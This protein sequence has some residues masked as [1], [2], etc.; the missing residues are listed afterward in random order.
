VIE[1]GTYEELCGHEQSRFREMVQSSIA[2]HLDQARRTQVT[3]LLRH[4]KD[5][6][7]QT[8]VWPL[9]RPR[10]IHVYNLGAGRT[11]TT[12]ITEVFSGVFRASHEAH[13]AETATLLSDYLSDTVSKRDVKRKLI[14]RDRR[15]RLEFESSPFLAGLSAP[16]AEAFPRAQFLLTVRPPREWL[17]SNIDKCINS[18]RTDLPP[19]F[20]HLRDLNYGPPPE[21]YPPPESILSHYNL[22]SLSGFLK[23]RSWHHATVLDSIPS[24]RRL[25]IKTSN[26]DRAVPRIANFLGVSR[27]RLSKSPKKNAAPE[28]H[29]ILSKIDHDYVLRLIERHCGDTIDRLEQAIE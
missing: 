26:L 11:G 20:V 10:R 22:H 14:A 29:G 4:V 18:P 2:C 3:D 12:A 24:D 6:V 27:E 28:R 23:Y 5:A 8:P 1:Y 17:R 15:W 16:L 9:L 19:H 7:K 13:V 21:Q 25:I